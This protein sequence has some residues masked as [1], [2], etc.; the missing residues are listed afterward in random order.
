M[1]VI[2]RLGPGR[3]LG[4]GDEVVTRL[5]ARIINLSDQPQGVQAP[6]PDAEFVSATAPCPECHGRYDENAPWCKECG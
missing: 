5:Y 6:H 2:C 4:Y 3:Y 1:L